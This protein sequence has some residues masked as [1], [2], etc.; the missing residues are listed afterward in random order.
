MSLHRFLLQ[1]VQPTQCGDELMPGATLR[2]TSTELGLRLCFEVAGRDVYVEVFPFAGHE[3]R[4]HAARSERLLFT[5][6]S[7]GLVGAKFEALGKRLCEV[8]A[9]RARNFE[10]EALQQVEEHAR[11]ARRVDGEDKQ[12]IREVVVDQLLERSGSS[13]QR[14]YTL[15]PYVGCLIGC[16]FCYAAERTA[17]ARQLEGLPQAPW[18]SYVDVRVNAPEILRDELRRLPPAPIKFCPIVSDPY[19]PTE[20]RYRL[21][22]ACLEVIAEEAPERQVLLLS[23]SA[24]VLTDLD[25]MLR[26]PRLMVG[27]S[28]PTIDDA[29]RKHFE[30]RGA[31]IEERLGQLR[32]LRDAGVNTFAVV[33]PMLPGSAEDLADALAQACT[34][35]SI[36]VL[37]GVYGAEAEF[38]DP[39][40]AFAADPTW[41]VQ[42]A[43]ALA[44]ALGER[45]VP[46]WRGELPPDLA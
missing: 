3:R 26:L 27:A 4:P 43:R 16:K 2:R 19:Q 6:R 22:R 10:T 15:S 45:G 36:D 14:F 8:V 34:S 33:Q 40:Y 20:A 32:Q 21:T 18:G 28:I 1:L 25:V 12:R 13:K 5:Y 46:L 42:Q 24:R 17:T 9:E 39:R 41:Q 31:T 7:R 44:A 37:Q 11:S 35:V 30:A 29:V 38:S 23:R